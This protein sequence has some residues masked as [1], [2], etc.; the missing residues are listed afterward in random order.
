MKFKKVLGFWDIFW[1]GIG[2]MVGVAILT[3]PSTTYQQAGPS[4]IIAWILAGVFSMFMA[5]IYSEM[6]TAFPRSGALVVF[7]Y[8]AFGKGKLARYLAFLEGT[9]YYIGTVFGIVISAIILGD[10]ISPA[11]SGGIG[12]IA[13]AEVALLITGTINVFGVKITSRIN[14]LM[15]IFF[16]AIFAIIIVLALLHGNPSNLS[17]F[18]S[19]S[20]GAMGI[21]LAIPIA[22]LAY[23]SWT[24]LITIPEE[25]AQVKKIPKAVFWS[26]LA[27]TIFYALLVLA[28]YLNVSA[29][30]LNDPTDLYPVYILVSLLGS[31]TLTAVF[32]IGAV[33]AIAA[34]ML[35]MVLSNARILY[36]LANLNFLPQSMNKMNNSAI[37]IYA[38][39]LSFIIPMALSVFPDQYYQYVVIGAI[40]GTGLPRIIDLASYLKIRN[41][42][43][44]HPSY[45]VRYGLAVALIA[46]AGL[47]ISE[48]SLG[49]S[50][51]TWSVAAFVL[52]TLIFVAVDWR[53]K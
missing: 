4:A 5:F 41:V 45:R 28:V 40:I 29:K 49:I 12:Q 42:P 47:V 8:E 30:S 46:F 13:I 11:F 17:P 39:L 10:Y 32:Q 51:V 16:M 18:F 31:S 3:F 19:G 25:T 22:I 2:G 44:Y 23:G 36:A 21:I 37:P 14:I 7:P 9:G 50:D 52:L 38:T 48:L 53:R 1:L 6:V 33:L 20:S 43:S 15:S 35:V 24:V 27:V 26:I 34:V